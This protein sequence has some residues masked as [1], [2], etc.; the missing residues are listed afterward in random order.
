MRLV[1]RSLRLNVQQGIYIFFTNSQFLGATLLFFTHP[2]FLF[3]ET[4][5]NDNQNVKDPSVKLIDSL[6]TNATKLNEEQLV[7]E[8]Y[9]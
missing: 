9:V 6:N 2:Q 8:E 7:L 1:L 5:D 3:L 4:D